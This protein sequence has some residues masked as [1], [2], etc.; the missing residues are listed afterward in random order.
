MNLKALLVGC[1]FYF[2]LTNADAATN[3]FLLLWGRTASTEIT[4]A[5]VGYHPF[6][7]PD[8]QYVFHAKPGSVNDAQY[9]LSFHWK[10]LVVATFTNSFQ[11]QVEL[12]GLYRQIIYFKRFDLNYFIGVMTGYGHHAEGNGGPSFTHSI[13]ANDPGLLIAFDAQLLLTKKISFHIICPANFR[14]VNFGIGYTF[15]A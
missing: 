2:V 7:P 14:S 8:Q 6:D 9:L 13:V 1:L 15:G 4:F 11:D 3:P 12:L 5:P 10:S